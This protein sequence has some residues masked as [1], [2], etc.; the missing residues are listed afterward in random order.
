VRF[1]LLLSLVLGSCSAMGQFVRVA[2]QGAQLTGGQLYSDAGFDLLD[3]NGDGKLDIFLPNPSM[4]AASVHLNEGSQTQPRFGRSWW[5]P[6]NYTETEP[7]T[8]VFNQMQTLCDLNHDGLFD[9]ILF[10]GRLRMLYNTGTTHGPNHW[11][12][13]LPAPFFPGSQRMLQENARATFA[14]ESMYWGKGIFP[15]QV[16]TTTVADWDGD[17]LE[18]LLI[19]RFKE[20]AP[21]ML[22]AKLNW[23]EKLSQAPAR[24]LYFYKNVGTRE[25]PW[26]DVG[27]EV[28]TPDGQSIAAPNPVVID[29][30]GD[31]VL[32]LVST[33]TAFACN[34]FRVDWPTNPSVIWFRRIDAT[35]LQPA[36]PVL[37]AAKKPI[38]AGTQAK[39][40]D[41]RGTGLTD[42]FVQDPQTGIRWYRNSAKKPAYASPTVLQGADFAR[43]GFMSQP[44]VVNWFGPNSRDLLIHG[45]YDAHCQKALRRTA[46]YRNVATRPGEIRYEFAG[47]FNYQGEPAMVPQTPLFEASDYDIYGSYVAVLPANR[48]VMSVS[49]KLYLF[50]N[51][52]A[53]GFTFQERKPLDIPNSNPGTELVRSCPVFV[54]WNQDGKLDLVLGVLNGGKTGPA[55]KEYRLYLNR[56]TNENPKFEDYLPFCDETGKPI[57][58]QAVRAPTSVAPQCGV[59]VL[60]LNGDGKLDLVIEDALPRNGL[61]TYQN[62]S[63][64]DLRFQFVKNLGDPVPIEY[65]VGYRYFY[66]G[67]TDGDGVPDLINNLIYFKGVPAAAPQPVTD[68]AFVGS[69]LRWTK[70]EGAVKYDLRV[71]DQ[72]EI[73]EL[74]WPTLPSVTGDYTSTTQTARLPIPAGKEM[75]VA[76]KSSNANSDTAPVSDSVAVMPSP[77]RR[78]VL[79]NAQG[80]YLDATTPGRPTPRQPSKLE[81]RTTSRANSSVSPK[82]KVILLRFQDLPRLAAL[83]RATLE[84]TTDPTL[85]TSPVQS[86]AGVEMSCS[87]IRDDWDVATATFIEAAPG[88]PWAMEELNA[89]GM[90]LS[91]SPLPFTVGPRRTMTWDVT[92]AVREALQAG[93]TTVSLLVR[94]EYTGKYSC[95]AGYNF[96]G[97]DWPQAEYRPRLCLLTKE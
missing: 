60:D 18:D 4:I 37:D 63:T 3:W 86:P 62:V 95:N 25:K 31:G 94:A 43:F 26:F 90:F 65:T 13:A 67:D 84:L 96:C 7:E 28:T 15:R 51:L 11:N 30:N 75:W 59:A 16:L 34:S 54:D 58:L 79:R 53:D 5:Y 83:D 77:L 70:P 66:F 88:K 39:F 92:R 40:A 57:K 72:R 93:R 24:G 1:V 47:Y 44:V 85:A 76:V 38:P 55:E 22:G 9:I 68:L 97:P 89:G 21:K 14:P 91:K 50:S 52:A 6:M 33:E 48:L 56:G 20:E 73:T 45:C 32:D 35:H 78:L 82:Q 8:V 29:M 69:E 80:A 23:Q 19:C 36:G 10:D 27:L 12:L 87:A 81:A 41:F 46:L 2:S 42:L 49:G 64:D 71:S 61:R 74:D 17:G